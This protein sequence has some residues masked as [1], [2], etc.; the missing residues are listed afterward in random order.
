MGW[1]DTGTGQQLRV[2]NRVD[3]HD[4]CPI[5]NPSD[6]ALKDRPTHWRDD[7]GIMER[8]CVH[9]IGH[10]DP[11]DINVRNNDGEGIHSCDGCC[12]KVADARDS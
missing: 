11:D 5:H 4:N 10:P 6:H 2:H 9:G 8:I 12:R 3:C 7:R 1:Y